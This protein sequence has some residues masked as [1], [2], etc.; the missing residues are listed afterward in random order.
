MKNVTEIQ[1]LG[2]DTVAFYN[3]TDIIMSVS[4][5]VP[6][7]SVYMTYGNNSITLIFP[8]AT[9]F[10]F[11]VL[12][13]TQVGAVTYTALT[14]VEPQEDITT[15]VL[16]IYSQLASTIFK[17]CCDCG[18]GTAGCT[19]EY[20]YNS[21]LSTGQWFYD[22]G[23]GKLQLSETSYLGQNFAGF[24]PVLPN[25]SWVFLV[26]D[27]DP[28]LYAIFQVSNYGN[29]GT[30]I[31]YDAT[32][33][34]GSS[35]FVVNTV[36][37]VSLAAAGGS[38]IV[39]ITAGNAGLSVSG[40]YPS[41][42]I[43][44]DMTISGGTGITIGGT[45]PNYVINSTG[46]GTGTVTSID[47]NGG[48]GI[49]VSPAGPIT[50]SG[51]F[52]VTN[53]APDQVVALT[54][55]TGISTSG[56][57][58]NFTITNTSPDQT[59]SLGTTGTGLAVTG[60]YPSFTLQNTLPDQTVALT[61]GTGI[62]VSGTYPS[63]TITNTSPS[64]G[65]TVT[66]V[67][68]TMP[69]AFSVSGTPVTGSG[70]LGVT[71]TGTS[72]QYIDG[73]GALQTLPTGLPPTGTAGG[74][75]SGT[76]PNPTVDGIHGIDMQSG[77][78]TS[79]DVWV[80]GG[81]PAKWQHQML[82]ASQVDNDS[83]VTGTHVSDALDHLNTTKVDTTRT[84]STTSPLT[85]GGDLSANRTLSIPAATS[86]VNGYLTSTDW[87]TFNSKE[88][89]LTFSSPLSRATN[90]ISI[91]AATGSVNGYLT[92]TDWTTFNSKQP[93]LNGTGFVKASGTTISYDNSTYLTSAITSLG[94]LTGATQTLATGTTGTDF[95]ISSAG[96]THTFNL[97]TASATNTGKLSSTDWSTFNG[98]A[99]L[100]SPAFTGTPTAPTA[101]AGTNTTQIATTAFVNTAIQSTSPTIVLFRDYS[102]A[103][104][105]GTTTNTL[106]WSTSVNANVF[107]TNDLLE[108]R[109]YFN[110]NAANGTTTNWRL[111]VNTSASLVG[112]TQ[113]AA[114]ANSVGTG[115]G[116]FQ[117][118][119]FVTATGASGSL[120]SLPVGA[121]STSSYGVS[122]TAIANYTVDTTVTLYFIWA[123]QLGN[124]ANTASMQGTIATLT[125]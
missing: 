48:T 86:S 104:L 98:K 68:L 30:Y 78:P 58:P 55:G 108:I 73:T 44:N 82:H 93:Q 60:T 56:T 6:N 50:T 16:A 85:G 43:S 87:T 113:I 109:S 40:S 33:I 47:V 81:S 74:D 23:A 106:V 46:G 107:Q 121:S 116:G 52:T 54:A 39:S 79:G 32:L 5:V 101:G 27:A 11:S 51:T 120:R 118:H 90:T 72:L 65:G 84:I 105:T 13:I 42:T 20:Q 122:N 80:Y 112:A 66:S 36:F 100:A 9:P 28:T 119:I 4:Q 41:F 12:P 96:T 59:V 125:R 3:G 83:A 62:S 71:A 110:S 61:S 7:T 22:S 75:L 91:P 77:T 34:D 35:T 18:S 89:A 15:R 57:Y 21:D 94:G 45:Y 10:T 24:Y 92:S 25:N 29:M 49:S 124:S 111:Y 76:Y 31:E 69:S 102:P 103:S 115:N 70:T 8:S 19:I 114:Y 38:A 2:N 117:R 14:G 1:V 95:A 99:G 63:F 67:G 17:G 37:C 26:S 88:S 97:P 123:I 53:T 64:S